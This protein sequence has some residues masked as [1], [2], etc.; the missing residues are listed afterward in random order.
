MD[1]FMKQQVK[2]RLFI[3]FGLL[4]SVLAI[5]GLGFRIL[6]PVSVLLAAAFSLV[7]LIVGIS[8]ILNRHSVDQDD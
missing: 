6:L 3:I 4:A 5:L 2:Q 7:V 8:L 1:H